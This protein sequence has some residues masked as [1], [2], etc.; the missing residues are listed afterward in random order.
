[1]VR[2]SSAKFCKCLMRESFFAVFHLSHG[3][4]FLA[5]DSWRCSFAVP[6]VKIRWYSD[7]VAPFIIDV[8]IG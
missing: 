5:V 2:E 4:N 8:S 7:G 1:M 6:L 3:P